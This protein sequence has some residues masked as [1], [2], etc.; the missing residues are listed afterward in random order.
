MS[1]NQTS[2]DSDKHHLGKPTLI[3]VIYHDKR[4]C[5]GPTAFNNNYATLA[6]NRLASL[7]QHLK[8]TGKSYKLWMR[9]LP[10][11]SDCVCR[12]NRT[13]PLNALHQLSCPLILAL[14]ISRL[15]LQHHLKTQHSD[16]TA[17]YR[18]SPCSSCFLYSI[19]IHNQD[20]LKPC[21]RINRHHH[22]GDKT[23]M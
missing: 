23:K 2:K 17:A 21:T 12:S 8:E 18:T 20:T 19:L 5:P 6:R 10:Y 7:W 3:S 22:F 13:Q 9:T 1:S 15:A 11:H 14:H 16:V 4:D